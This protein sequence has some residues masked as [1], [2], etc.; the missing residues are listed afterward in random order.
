MTVGPTKR[1]AQAS[2]SEL[3]QRLSLPGSA[4]LRGSPHHARE[5]RSRRTPPHGARLR[6]CL[7]HERTFD[8]VWHLG[9][10][11]CL[12]ACLPASPLTLPTSTLPA[13]DVVVFAASATHR[14]KAEGSASG[15]AGG[16]GEESS[17][18]AWY[19]KL[20][21]SQ[22]RVSRCWSYSAS[23]WDPLLVVVGC[24]GARRCRTIVRAH[25]MR[26]AWWNDGQPCTFVRTRK[27]LS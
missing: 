1:G 2:E 3:G 4:R 7:A 15:G 11:A 6:S 10:R 12:P 8:P 20:S 17:A 23:N 22:E 5:G 24:L 25:P 16:A 19:A 18:S 26:T 21:L 9:G 27:R 13:A 14:I